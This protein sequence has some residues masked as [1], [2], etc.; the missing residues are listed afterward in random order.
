MIPPRV[1]ILAWYIHNYG[2][3][4]FIVSG[5][6]IFGLIPGSSPVSITLGCFD[7][8]ISQIGSLNFS[9]VL[10]LWILETCFGGWGF[11]AVLEE[12]FECFSAK[13]GHSLAVMIMSIGVI[14]ELSIFLIKMV[15]PFE[16]F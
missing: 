2:L 1:T 8:L 5:R 13:F 10:K 7:L 3:D 15:P 9:G 12:K 14:K 6:R 4:S 16:L 11:L